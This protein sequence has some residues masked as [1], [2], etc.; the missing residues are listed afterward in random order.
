MEDSLECCYSQQ[1]TCLTF[2]TRYFGKLPT[3][4]ESY[5][6]QGISYGYHIIQYI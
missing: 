5:A 1:C 3:S 4:K 6:Y 2:E